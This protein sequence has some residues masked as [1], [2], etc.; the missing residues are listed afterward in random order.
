[1][2]GRLKLAALFPL[3]PTGNLL[4]K[5]PSSLLDVVALSLAVLPQVP[6]VF[7]ILGATLTGNTQ[8]DGFFLMA[9]N[10]SIV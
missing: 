1:M 8:K 3:P 9:F 10:T 7:D 5:N 2:P 4:S 6:F